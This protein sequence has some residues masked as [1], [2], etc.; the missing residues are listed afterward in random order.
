MNMHM[1]YRIRPILASLI[2]ELSVHIV[3]NEH[4]LGTRYPLTGKV[5]SDIG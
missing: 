5:L 1:R 2:L 4:N 3:S